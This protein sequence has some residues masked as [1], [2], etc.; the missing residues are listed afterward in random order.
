M[1]VAD[2]L[3]GA[4]LILEAVRELR[5]PTIFAQLGSKQKVEFRHALADIYFVPDGVK[6][7]LEQIAAGHPVGDLSPLTTFNDAESQIER[8]VDRLSSDDYFKLVEQFR[9][10]EALTAIFYKKLE[11]RRNIQ[12]A[13]NEALTYGETID[14]DVARSLL[15]AVNSLNQEIQAFDADLARG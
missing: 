3:A 4:T 15:E 12:D 2:T 6:S 13:L 9:N 10:K 14:P 1:T 8:L 7:I 5:N 11:L